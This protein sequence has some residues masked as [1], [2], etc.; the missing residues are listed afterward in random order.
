MISVSPTFHSGV[1]LTAMGLV[2]QNIERLSLTGQGR[3]EGNEREEQCLFTWFDFGAAWFKNDSGWLPIQRRQDKNTT[4][5]KKKY[6]KGNED[7]RIREK[8]LNIGSVMSSTANQGFYP[9][10]FKAQENSQTLRPSRTPS[11]WEI[12]SIANQAPPPSFLWISSKQG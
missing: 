6:S 12:K 7:K 5:L 2:V 1:A 9:F 11:G 10:D 8:S 4:R 3:R